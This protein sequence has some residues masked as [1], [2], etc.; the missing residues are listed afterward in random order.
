MGISIQAAP[1]CYERGSCSHFSCVLGQKPIYM[2]PSR[3]FLVLRF[4]SFL[5]YPSEKDN[6]KKKNVRAFTCQSTLMLDAKG[7]SSHSMQSSD[8]SPSRPILLHPAT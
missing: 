4:S 5:S 8:N 1:T 6:K 7:G 2:L 3:R